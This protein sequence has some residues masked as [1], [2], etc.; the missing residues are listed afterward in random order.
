MD[1]P[2]ARG[3]T[4]PLEK[5]IRH[6]RRRGKASTSISPCR[7]VQ[8]TCYSAC[9]GIYWA[10]CAV[11]LARLVAACL[12]G[13]SGGGEEVDRDQ[14]LIHTQHTGTMMRRALLLPS[15]SACSSSSSHRR[16]L[17][18]LL[19]RA[20]SSTSTSTRSEG[21]EVGLSQSHESHAADADT[22]T[23]EPDND[24][25]S[26]AQPGWGLFPE[27]IV[28]HLNTYI[29]SQGDAK[30]ATAIAMRMRW[31]RN[32][33]PDEIRAEVT[34]SNILMKGPTGTGKTEIARRL[35]TLAEAP[36]IKVEATR[37]TEVVSTADGGWRRRERRR[38]CSPCV[39]V[40]QRDLF[41]CIP[42]LLSS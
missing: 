34:P 11:G 12:N 19:R 32:Q 25:S 17:S 31:R 21:E 29:V 27:D 30:K 9:Y 7:T 10:V 18:P 1:G 8:A 5:C 26:S 41:E 3:S 42:L 6:Q 24:S 15:F 36:F 22:A 35:S 33:L 38:V 14:K 13:W 20:A 2:D 4:L 28:A 39:N 37:Y 40:H 23:L 16:L